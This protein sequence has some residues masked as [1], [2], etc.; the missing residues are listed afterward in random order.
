MS[1]YQPAEPIE[2][3]NRGTV[4]ALLA[5]PVGVIVWVLIWT[6]GFIASIVTFAVAYLAMFL[7]RL[8]SGGAMGRA[9]AVRV[10]IITLVTLAV[11]IIAG[12]VADVAVGLGRITNTGPIEALG[13][14]QFGEVF[15]DYVTDPD[16]GLLLSLGLAIGFGILGC[17]GVLRAAFGAQAETPVAPA[18]A[19]YYPSLAQPAAP[20][21]APENF[22]SVLDRIAQAPGATQPP[23][24][25]NPDVPQFPSQLQQPTP[26]E[27]QD[28]N[29]P[30]Y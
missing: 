28:P 8:G 12:L 20:Q 15:N 21:V 11:S 2:D 26:P 10:A 17:F 19:A 3:V 30:R 5:I 14:P 16:S 6:L 27:Q 9:G 7:Y 24:N 29:A 1:T 23:A 4:V 22:Q 13:L 25:P 18:Q